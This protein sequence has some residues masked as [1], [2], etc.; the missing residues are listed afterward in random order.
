MNE[1]S[2]K[3][4]LIAEHEHTKLAYYADS[5]FSAFI[6]HFTDGERVLVSREYYDG[7]EL[8]DHTTPYYLVKVESNGSFRIN[9]QRHNLNN[10]LRTNL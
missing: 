1:L 9:G 7:G 2:E 3:K 4:Q 10:Y 5:A 6:I 8:F